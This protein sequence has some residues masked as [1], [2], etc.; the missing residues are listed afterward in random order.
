MP[1]LRAD[2]LRGF[3]LLRVRDGGEVANLQAQ[4]DLGLVQVAVLGHNGRIG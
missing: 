2:T 3:Q 4:G 1:A